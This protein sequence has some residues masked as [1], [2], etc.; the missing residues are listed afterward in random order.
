VNVVVAGSYNPREL[1]VENVIGAIQLGE[2]AEGIQKHLAYDHGRNDEK[3]RTSTDAAVEG[4]PAFFDVVE[5]DNLDMIRCW[6]KYG[7]DLNATYGPDGCP[8]LAF[9]ILHGRNT[10]T[11]QQ[12]TGTLE[13]LL[14]LG[15]S[16]CII[17]Q[18]F[19][20]PFNRSLPASGPVNEELDD[21]TE[22]QKRWC[23]PR[24]RKEPASALDLTQRYRLFQATHMD[25]P[26]RRQQI[27]A[28]RTDAERILGLQYTVLGQ[29]GAVKSLKRRLMAWVPHD[30]IA[31]QNDEKQT[32]SACDREAIGVYIRWTQRPRQD[33][34]RAK[35]WRIDFHG[36]D[37]H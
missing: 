1:L 13:M 12:V 27:L 23:D 9:A 21:R 32:I 36:Y 33:R 25:P 20:T 16:P 26:S 17:P 7:G 30:P 18:A 5:T 4:F 11:L 15:A 28:S 34:D 14:T 37:K 35:S 22:E 10:R 2:S 29:E 24:L 6:A 31:N 19:Y 3:L 8:L